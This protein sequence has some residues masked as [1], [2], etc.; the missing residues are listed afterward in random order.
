MGQIIV[1]A[2]PRACPGP[3][4]RPDDGKMTLAGG[5][6]AVY[7][8]EFYNFMDVPNSPV[9]FVGGFSVAR[10]REFYNFMDVPNS[11][12]KKTD[13]GR[14]ADRD[15]LGRPVLGWIFGRNL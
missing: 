5:F 15:A 11:Q 9:L 13:Y 3:R 4:G 10:F 14:F 8:G 6:S 1:G 12:R 2:G 7:S